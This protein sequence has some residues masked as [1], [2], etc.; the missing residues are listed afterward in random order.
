M[1]L[2]RAETWVLS[3]TVMSGLSGDRF[4][5]L[6]STGAPELS[7]AVQFSYNVAFSAA[8]FVAKVRNLRVGKQSPIY[9]KTTNHLSPYMPKHEIP[10]SVLDIK[11]KKHQEKLC[12]TKSLNDRAPIYQFM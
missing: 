2:L 4:C 7:Q 3:G 10:Q 6:T 8:A 5:F 9:A 1:K 11:R 12:T